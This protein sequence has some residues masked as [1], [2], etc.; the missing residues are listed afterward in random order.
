MVQK[1]SSKSNRNHPAATDGKA[2]TALVISILVG[3][4][5]LALTWMKAMV[6]NQDLASHAV[7][8]SIVLLQG[9]GLGFFW[10]RLQ[11][12]TFKTTVSWF[13]I[14]TQW[15]YMLGMAMKGVA[16][17]SG[18]LGGEF[19]TALACLSMG[20]CAI[21][22]L[23]FLFMWTLEGQW[24]Q[25]TS[26][27]GVMMASVVL[28]IFATGRHDGIFEDIPGKLQK[29]SLSAKAPHDGHG[30]NH[31]EEVVV[32]G[33]EPQATHEEQGSLDEKPVAEHYTEEKHAA[34]SEKSST[35][36]DTHWEYEGE[37]GPE[38]WGALK[39]E[40]SACQTGE[41][42]SPIDI[43]RDAKVLTNHLKFN[44]QKSLPTIVDNGHTIQVN[45]P[46]GSQV[47]VNGKVYEF[48]QFHFHSPS[49][50]TINGV[51][52]PLEFHFVHAN[53]K[54]NL[55][56]LGVM[57]ERGQASDEFNKLI[58][59]LPEPGEK[60]SKPEIKLNLTEFYPKMKATYHYPGSL[61]TPP[62][63]EGVNWNVF[64]NPIQMS[65]EQIQKF[66]D[67]Y[68]RNNRPTQPL[69][70]RIIGL[71]NARLMSH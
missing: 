62:C 25:K 11:D 48:K 41:E 30:K 7:G 3:I 36:G 38:Y 60:E 15:F 68:F 70:H 13:Y 20:G 39:P 24:Q 56:V 63:S 37:N 4:P 18:I 14:F 27:F 44:Y 67:R 59:N 50:H 52:Y 65:E 8:F 66:K 43:N 34:P 5:F 22:G 32:A 26:A 23:A 61:T 49:E 47:A 57:V 71:D 55:A 6:Q 9:L 16:P 21:T 19:D 69:N 1:S 40:F 29:S 17:Q 54:G 42:Q 31:E 53:A 12:G 46:G 2:P 64:K 28:A 35:H 10:R 58:T 33:H 51:S 45:F